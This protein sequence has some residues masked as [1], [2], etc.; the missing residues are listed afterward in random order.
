MGLFSKKEKV[1]FEA[2]TSFGRWLQYDENRNLIKI[3]EG[4]KKIIPVEDIQLYQVKCGTKTYN[5]ANL[6]KA[7]VGGALFG[8]A[9]VVLA[10]TH[11]EEYISNLNILIKANDKFYSI[12]MIIGKMKKSSAKGV[13]EQA[14][15]IVEFLDSICK[16]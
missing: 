4:I 13:I 15:K 9:G 2:T 5:K 16:N 11:E 1:E 10:G 7:A 3:T 8:V 14:D 6:G 12:P